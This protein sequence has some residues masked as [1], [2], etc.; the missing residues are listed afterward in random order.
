MEPTTEQ[1]YTRI[2]EHNGPRHPRLHLNAPHLR[3]PPG[4]ISRTASQRS[5]EH[6]LRRAVSVRA[7]KARWE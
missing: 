3:R 6:L 2:D 4:R 5:D 1:Y 7:Y